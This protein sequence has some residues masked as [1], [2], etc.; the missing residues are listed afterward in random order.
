MFHK[1]HNIRNCAFCWNSST[2]F[3]LT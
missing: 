2:H 1:S 3:L